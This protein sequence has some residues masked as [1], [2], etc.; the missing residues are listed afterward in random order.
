MIK[1]RTLLAAIA[2]VAMPMAATAQSDSTPEANDHKQV[3]LAENS[4]DL[5]DLTPTGE[6]SIVARNE[7]DNM[8]LMVFVIWND[9]PEVVS[10]VSL[11]IDVHN[12]DGSLAGVATTNGSIDIQPSVLQ[13]GDLA[14]GYVY[15]QD[16]VIVSGMSY[17]F[18]LTTEP[19][20]MMNDMF[21]SLEFAGV[22]WTGT[23]LIGELTNTGREEISMQ[24]FVIACFDDDGAV[25]GGGMD[26]SMMTVGAGE[27]TTFQT[28]SLI[29]NA[30]CKNF[31]L[32]GSGL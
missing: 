14:I 22:T 31:I 24:S 26:A 27:T 1:L 11:K 4:R 16:I 29:Y 15:L 21:P 2:I 18:S 25:L 12:A 28:G 7:P 20:G 6:L 30:D 13:P 23:A 10:N 5:L 19:I 9:T 8:G 17:E 3:S 32:A